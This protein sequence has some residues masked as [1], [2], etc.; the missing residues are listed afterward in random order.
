MGRVRRG[1]SIRVRM[2]FISRLIRGFELVNFFFLGGRADK[3][4]FFWVGGRINYFLGGRQGVYCFTV[5]FFGARETEGLQ[6]SILAR[7]RRF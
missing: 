2:S 5:L 1:I 6:T 7:R 3:L 4:V